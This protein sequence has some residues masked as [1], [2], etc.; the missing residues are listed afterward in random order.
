MNHDGLTSCKGHSDKYEHCFK[1]IENTEA[2]RDAFGRFW[3]D[4]ELKITEEDIEALKEGK[5]LA[6][7]VRREE[8]AIFITLVK[9]GNDCTPNAIK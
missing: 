8:Y 7:T 5:A 9:H 6:A 3:D 4:Q 1:V 2:A